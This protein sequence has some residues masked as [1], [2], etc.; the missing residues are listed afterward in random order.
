MFEAQDLVNQAIERHGDRIAVACSFGK[1]SMI[2]LRMALNCNSLIK[3]IFNNTSAEFRETINFKNRMKKEWNLNLYETVPLKTFWQCIDEYGLPTV[4]K[5]K[6]K[7]SNASRCCYYLKEK[8]ALILQREL[9]VNAI[10]TGMQACE[11]RN[12]ALLAKRYDNKKAPYMSKDNVEFCSQRW[13]TRSTDTWGYHPIMLWSTN[14]VWEYTADNNI[15]INEVYTKWRKSDDDRS[16]PVIP[17]EGLYPRCGC[18]PWT[19]YLSWKDRLPISHP[20]LYNHLIKLSAKE[21]GNEQ[22]MLI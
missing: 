10:I 1:D 15:P 13:Y 12:R 6:G 17:G 21:G 5:N 2:V 16:L 11:N 19:A 3:V 18:L 7:G 20:R 9:G 22:P 8:P 4:R 14:R